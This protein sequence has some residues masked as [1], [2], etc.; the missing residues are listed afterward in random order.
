MGE[1]RRDSGEPRDS[2]DRQHSGDHEP[3]S[4]PEPETVTER[5]RRRRGLLMLGGAF[6]ALVATVATLY[7]SPLLALRSIEVSGN[8]LLTD[9]R[10]QELVESFYGE[11]LPQV[12]TADIRAALEQENVVADVHSRAELPHT[13]HVEIQEH[14]P[15]AEVHEDEAVLFYND[16]GEVIREFRGAQVMDAE[17]YATP[18]VSAEAALEDEAVFAAIVSVLGQLPES[19]REQMSAASAE[20][21]D[22]VQLELADERVVVWGSDDRGEEKAAVL[23]AILASNAEDFAEAQIIDIS[24][25]S[26]P[27]TR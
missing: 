24:T 9:A 13:L 10:A 25:P 22:S 17:G 14:P 12:S 23:E 6:L 8:D 18:E 5:R 1:P 16:A 20:S 2:G 15:V 4:F 7:F 11:P 26:T 27:V 19:A 3:L 21:I